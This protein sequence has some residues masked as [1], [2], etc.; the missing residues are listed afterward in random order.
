MGVNYLILVVAIIHELLC[1]NRKWRSSH[2]AMGNK[3]SD[4][5]L[6]HGLLSGIAIF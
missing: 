2:C 5:K 1:E 3:T 6:D 4:A